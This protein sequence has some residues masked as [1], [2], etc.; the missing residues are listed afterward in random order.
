MDPYLVLGVDRNASREHIAKSYRVLAS[1]YHPDKNPDPEAAAKFKEVAAAF[2]V[3]GDEDKRRHF[4]LYGNQVPSFSFRS[5]NSVDD[6]FDNIF[7]NFFGNQK[8]GPSGSRVRLKISLRDAYFGCDRKIS[9]EKHKFCSACQGTGSSSWKSCS[10]CAGKGF[11][12]TNNGQ[13]KVQESCSKCQGKGSFSEKSCADC[14]GKGYSVDS[15]KELSV[16]IPPGIDDG[17]QIRIAGEAADGSDLFVVVSVDK[18]PSFVR[19]DRFLIGNIEAP[20]STLVLG[21]SVDMDL[22]GTKISIK[23]PPRMNAGSRMR[24]KGQGMPL[25]QNPNM[26]GDLLVDIRLKMP[27]TVDK[28]H[29]NLLD[30]LSKIDIRS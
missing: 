1:K 15:V 30:S 3:I 26:R 24:I 18:D 12:F 21:G 20:Y 4:D 6:V 22:F 14:Q 25:I 13:I 9:T 8:K 29:A 17:N 7:S 19:Q 27:K 10:N 23:I 5:R 11:L 28:D 2:E 16:K